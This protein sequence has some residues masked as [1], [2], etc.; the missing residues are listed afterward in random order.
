MVKRRNCDQTSDCIP[1]KRATRHTMSKCNVCSETADVANN[2]EENIIVLC[3]ECN[4]LFHGDCVGIP[5]KF[6]LMLCSSGRG[7]ACYDCIQNKMQFVE[8]VVEKVNSIERKVEVNS[9]KICN[10]QASVEA[11]LFA[12]NEKIEKVKSDLSI[13]LEQARSMRPA[14]SS[15]NSSLTPISDELAYVRSFQRRNNLIIQNIPP[16]V[17]ESPQS[18]KDI[19]MKIATCFGCNMDPD[20]IVIVTRL[21]NRVSSASSSSSG[22]SNSLSR[23]ASNSLLVKFTDVTVKDD[24]FKNYILSVT[25]KLF[26]MGK[27]IGLVTNP[28]IYI[29]HHLSPDLTRIKLKASEMKK[30]GLLSKINA[31]YD[32]IK[33]FVNESWH[34]VT[35][36]DTLNRWSSSNI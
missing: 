36:I 19:V 4:S 11:A 15:S 5:S 17:D 32:C 34:K 10:V 13:E 29:N 33:V 22:S 12:M 35:D 16:T 30:A 24:L 23:P 18:L 20:S 14:S 7:W 28:R 25:K 2:D 3:R 26:V 21:R 31:R 6:L 9:G 8:N 27:D 1:K